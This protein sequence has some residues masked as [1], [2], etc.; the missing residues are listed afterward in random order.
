MHSAVR[1]GRWRLIAVLSVA[2]AVAND[3]AG[4]AGAAR[5]A[6]T[7]RTPAVVAFGDSL[8][9]GPGLQRDQT[10]PALLQR[11]IASDGYKFRVVNAN[12]L[13]LSRPLLR[14]TD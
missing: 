1:D 9:S 7:I 5:R 4:A 2:L 11:K 8:T 14:K 3:P 6:Q 12:G 13:D 10:Y